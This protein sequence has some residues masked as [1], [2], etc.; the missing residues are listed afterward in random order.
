MQ[1]VKSKNKIEL[2]LN[3]SALVLML[4]AVLLLVVIGFTYAEDNTG[5]P[6]DVLNY[7]TGK[8]YWDH[9]SSRVG[10][11]GIY[12]LSLFDSLP[13]GADGEKTLAPGDSAK[14][15]IE[16]RNKAGHG[17]QY[18][19]V[20]YR[21]TKD[22]VP[23]Q[24]DFTN[25]SELNNAP[26]F[27]T[28]DGVTSEN[29][30]RAVRGNID[31]FAT[32]A[33]DIEW[34]WAY[35][36]G[37]EQDEF[38]TYLGNLE[39]SDVT[40]G[41]Y[42]TVI[43][44]AEINTS[45]DSINKDVDGD[46]VPDI[47]LDIDGDGEAEQNIDFDGD[48]IPDINIDTNGDGITDVN[49][50]IDGRGFY[51]GNIDTNGDGIPDR[52]LIAFSIVDDV[53]V[54]TEAGFDRVIRSAD[55]EDGTLVLKLDN[56]TGNVK[57]FNVPKNKL[58]ELAESDKE[59]KLVLTTIEMTI[60]A[61]ALDAI[62][63]EADGDNVKVIIKFIQ[64]GDLNH[65]QRFAIDHYWQVATAVRAYVMSGEKVINDF[66]KGKFDI[67]IPYEHY[68][69]TDIDDYVLHESATDGTLTD[70]DAEYSDGFYRFSTN[71][72]ADYLII[73]YGDVL[74][75][76]ISPEPP[77]CSCWICFYGETC[78]QCW[79]CWLVVACIVLAILIFILLKTGLL[80]VIYGKYGR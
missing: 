34:F 68:E 53:V 46:G 51:D 28:P 41:V 44:N 55:M 43:D 71:C 33:L 17:I 72:P 60:D 54:F 19:A 8:L 70:I 11:D 32:A 14:S 76:G 61:K 15:V 3:I 56:I 20:L 80:N 30:V 25:V 52:D 26:Q 73:Y 39:H 63:E 45:P 4:T 16:I 36:V 29:V 1:G 74:I 22:N 65:A 13:V 31:P 58:E 66:G 64:W 77:V 40:V 37:A 7:E 57:G 69:G 12:Q 49:L 62:I 38:D 9:E 67:A 21:I 24:T 5:I 2:I 59:I 42:I 47:N 10:E 78:N 35:S 27:I 75:G 79:I 48:D 6:K 23:I 18:T 50:D